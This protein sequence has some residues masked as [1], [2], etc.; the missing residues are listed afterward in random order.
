MKRKALLLF[1]V[2]SHHVAPGF[3]RTFQLNVKFY[4]FDFFVETWNGTSRR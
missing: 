2:S 1:T 3:E 4:T